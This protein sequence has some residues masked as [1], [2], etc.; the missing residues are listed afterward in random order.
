MTETL[1]L[2]YIVDGQERRADL[3]TEAAKMDEN[4]WNWL[5]AAFMLCGFDPQRVKEFFN[6][7]PGGE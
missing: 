1:R 2:S 3:I 4:T 7:E 6:N 5:K